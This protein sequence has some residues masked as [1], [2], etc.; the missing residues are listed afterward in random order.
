MSYIIH[1]TAQN[2]SGYFPDLQ[3][4]IIARML[5]VGVAGNFD[6]KQQFSPSSKLPTVLAEINCNLRLAEFGRD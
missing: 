3:T 2:S 5:S 4:I 6:Y 1:C